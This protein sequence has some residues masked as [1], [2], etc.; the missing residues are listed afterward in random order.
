MKAP[1]VALVAVVL[2]GGLA[3]T[4]CQGQAP[5]DAPR[6][7]SS[8][9]PSQGGKPTKGGGFA[10][11]APAVYVHYSAPDGKP[12]PGV[13]AIYNQVTPE[14][15]TTGTYFTTGF[16]EGYFGIQQHNAGKKN[17]IFSMYN[18]KPGTVPAG[19]E[20]GTVLWHDPAVTADQ[21]HEQYSGPSVRMPVNWQIGQPSGFLVVAKPDGTMTDL[22][23]YYYGSAASEPPHWIKL[24]VIKAYVKTPG[25]L[26]HLYNFAEDFQRTT[27]SAK[28]LRKA[29]YGPGWVQ[30]GSQ[31]QPLTAGSFSYANKPDDPQ[32]GNGGVDGTRFFLQNGGDTKQTQAPNQTV[33]RPAAGPTPPQDVLDLVKQNS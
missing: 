33:T 14:V 31:W 22:T 6:S 3:L 21:H 10:N 29:A 5:A 23:P 32:N 15:S 12:L 16:T 8:D 4:A 18:P 13:S 19:D 1:L 17:V 25:Q 27:E 2:T 9:S 26:D 30:T 24:A 7:S 28:E 20:K 11:G